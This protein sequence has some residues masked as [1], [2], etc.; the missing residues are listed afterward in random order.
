MVWIIFRRDVSTQKETILGI[1][2]N[3]TEAQKF[4]FRMNE[5]DGYY[6]YYYA[7]PYDLYDDCFEMLL[8]RE[9]WG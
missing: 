2:P 4:I 1:L 3:S 5:S 8:C 6:N 9:L 7:L